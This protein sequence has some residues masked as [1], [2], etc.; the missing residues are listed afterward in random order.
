[1]ATRLSRA[2]ERPLEDVRYELERGVAWITIARPERYNAFRGQTVDELLHCFKLA[3]ADGDVGVVVLTGEGDRAFCAGGDQKQRAE[4]GDYGPTDY[5][6]FQV[7]Q[8]HRIIRAIPKPVIAAVN[9]VAIG[10]GH[11]LHVL[12]DI[13]IAADHAIFGQNGPRVGSFDAGF[14]TSYLAR[15]VGEKRAREIWFLCRRYDAATAERWGLVNRVVPLAELR[16]EV[17]RWADEILALSPT[18]LRFLKQ[19]FNA[20]SE[21]IAGVGSLAFSGLHQFVDSAE[22]REGV[23]AF[24]TK[25]EP[26][27]APFRASVSA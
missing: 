19:S 12:A 9:G 7:E 6:L 16:A 5:G 3:W 15:V 11:V 8:L 4:T 13:T 20:D 26:D 21:H 23:E 27:F 1:M 17:R 18:S 24:A 14:G 22:A 2:A 10:G 25:R